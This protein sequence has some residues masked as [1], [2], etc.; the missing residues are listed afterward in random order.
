MNFDAW[1][2][3][4]IVEQNPRPGWQIILRFGGPSPT[5]RIG[6]GDPY[7]YCIPAGAVHHLEPGDPRPRRWALTYQ[8]TK[9]EVVETIDI[10]VDYHTQRSKK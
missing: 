10:A 3:L 4:H 6:L 7:F 9:E 2:L 8:M 5:E 1:Q